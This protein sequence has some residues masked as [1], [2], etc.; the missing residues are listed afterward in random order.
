MLTIAK[1]VCKHVDVRGGGG[2]GGTGGNC[3]LLDLGSK[4]RGTLKFRG[5]Q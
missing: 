1:A 2:G 3:P 5:V 4:N